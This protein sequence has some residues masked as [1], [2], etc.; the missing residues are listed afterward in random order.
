MIVAPSVKTAHGEVAVRMGSGGWGY[1][2][3]GV[4]YTTGAASADR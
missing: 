4:R 2:I 3:S 1:P